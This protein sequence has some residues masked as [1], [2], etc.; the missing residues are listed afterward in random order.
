MGE[1]YDFIMLKSKKLDESDKELLLISIVNLR[2]KFNS[3][4]KTII[5]NIGFENILDIKF[6]VPKAGDNR[7]ILDLSLRNATQFKI[8]KLKQVQIVDPRKTFV[9]NSRSNENRLEA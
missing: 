1:L 8:E 5:T 6:I 4:N 7:K 2:E 3:K 9:T